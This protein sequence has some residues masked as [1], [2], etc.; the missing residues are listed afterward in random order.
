MKKISFW[1]LAAILT[2]CATGVLTS[3]TEDDDN[4]DVVSAT[5]PFPYPKEYL[6]NK[7]NSVKPGDSFFD[8]CNGTW[9]ASTPISSDPSKNFGGL[10]DALT[11]MDERVEQLKSSVP[12]LTRF[13]S[14]MEQIHDKPEASRAYI[15]AQK[16]KIQKPQTKEEAY[17]T[18]GKMY[19]EGV[20]VLGM[21][22]SI[23]WDKDQLKAVLKPGGSVSMDDSEMEHHQTKLLQTRAASK[24][25]VPALLAEGMGFDPSLMVTDN[26]DTDIWEEY[27]DG[28][29]V[30]ELYGMMQDGWKRYEPFVSAPEMA[31]DG[32]D[33][34]PSEGQSTMEMLRAQARAALGYTI[35]YHFQQKF[36]P[37]SLKDKYLGITKEFQA[38]LRKRIQ[39]VD[40]MSETTKQNAIDKI[41]HYRLNV[42]FPDTWYTDCVPAL[43]DCETMVEA[44]HRLNAANARLLAKLVGTDDV[45]SFKLT[46]LDYDS[47][48]NPESLDL[49]LVNATYSPEENSVNI[50]PAMLMSPIM[51]ADGVSEACYYAV[52]SIIGHEMT[53]SFD[54]NGSRWD[55]YGKNRN[56]W[57]VADM[58]AF[59]DRWENLIR[60]YGNMELDPQRAPLVFC[61]GKRTLSE[62]IADLGGFLTALDAYI[63]RLDAQGFTGETRNEQLRKFYEAYAHLWCVQYGYEKFEVLKNSDPHAHARLRVNGV[64]MNTDLWY[65][66]YNVDR[67]HLLY[68]PP[69]RRAYIW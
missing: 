8:Y 14:L 1:M 16:A 5:D 52:F 49:T 65:E 36:V 61:D 43:A 31:G 27:W 24:T 32:N 56:W 19:V 3:C 58:M 29:T 63:A 10:Y 47:D 20:N 13:F 11:M 17:R 4:N 22:F 40:W 12:D 33:G 67:N 62:N 39:K 41:D 2:I 37:Q 55:K 59:Q 23:K 66:L 54:D 25:T 64:V 18:I 21:T 28:L 15:D 38:A 45:F 57:T 35:S 69:E 9:L 46:Q 44:M 26:E 51:P 6:A 42:A 48:G 34:M 53:H 50:F 60:T 30:D 7:D 68:L